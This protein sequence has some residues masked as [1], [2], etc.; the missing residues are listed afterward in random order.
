MKYAEEY[1]GRE[2][3]GMVQKVQEIN[4]VKLMNCLISFA[5]NGIKTFLIFR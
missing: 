5:K 2:E 1:V 4:L 3:Y